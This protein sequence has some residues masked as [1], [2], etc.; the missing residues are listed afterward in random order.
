MKKHGIKIVI[1]VAFVMLFCFLYT[2]K[3]QAAV[4]TGTTTADSLKVRTSAKLDGDVNRLKYQGMFVTLAKGTKVTILDTLKGWYQVQF[5]YGTT[6][7]QGYVSADYVVIAAATPTPTAFVGKTVYK[8]VTYYAPIS[9]PGTATIKTYLK[10]APAGTTQ[11]AY[12]KKTQN[13]TVLG[14][15]VKNSVKWFKVKEVYQKKTVIGYVPSESV[16]LTLKSKAAAKI[17]YIASKLNLKTGPSLSKPFYTVGGKKVVL[18]K[19]AKVSIV[20]DKLV[21]K[22][23]WYRLSFSYSGKVRKAY[24]QDK[25]VKL[26]K[27]KKTKKV[28][29]TLAMTSAQ[30]EA[31]LTDQ[32][33]PE[34]YKVYL[35]ALHKLYP[36]WEFN[37]YQTSMN[38]S[39][40][41]ANESVVGLN[42][43]PIT[44]ASDWKSKAEGAYNAQTGKYT[45]F[46]GSTWVTASEKAVK[47]YMDPR[48]FL[49]DRG[50]LQFEVLDYQPSYQTLA[51]INSILNNTP[52]YNG[53]YSYYEATKKKNLSITYANTFLAAAKA[54]GVSPY[55]LAARVRQEVVTG[56]T[57]TTIAVTGTT[58]Q[59]PGIFNFY[60]IG[61]YQGATPALNGLLWA[62]GGTSKATTYLRPWNN[63]YKAIVG[64]ATFLGETYINKGQNTNY[65]Q[66]FN[67]TTTKTY[68]HQ[69]MSNV[70]AASAESQNTRKAYLDSMSSMPILF[71]IPVY[72]NMPTQA[73]PMPN[74]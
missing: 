70:E 41:I 60:N 72:K 36:Y 34:S 18:K 49:T 19:N 71:S 38:W 16:L 22:G 29:T 48:N 45:V 56:K 47:Y 46:D 14:E 35:R 23:K 13:L 20:Q 26:A 59:Y 2:G 1:T 55:H 67:I 62:K 53:K 12:L 10:N 52:F 3:G 69:F 54:S 43:L 31:H 7:L 8:S 65:L 44:K 30:F 64:G 24:L 5:S 9:V 42:L 6:H 37:S 27:E 4:L 28:V 73:C 51:G 39:T 61:A 58:T 57:T 63:R 25:Y 68:T 40:A 11:K 17:F 15:S 50:I 21:S 66:K 32:G 33:F 74:S